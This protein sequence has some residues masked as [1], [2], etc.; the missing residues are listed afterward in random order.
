MTKDEEIQFYK[1]KL[2]TA[3]DEYKKLNS[4]LEKCNKAYKELKKKYDLHLYNVPDRKKTKS[5]EE[6]IY[7]AYPN[8]LHKQTTLIRIRRVLAEFEKAGNDWES[9]FERVKDYEKCLKRFGV[10]KNHELWRLVPTSGPWFEKGYYEKTEADWSA[11]FR[12]GRYIEEKKEP[13]EEDT[14]QPKIDELKA[15]ISEKYP[16]LEVDKWTWN[17][18]KIHEPEY[19]KYI[20]HTILNDK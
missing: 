9:L 19:A 4:R 11:P 18:I 15:I 5:I 6:K 3:R 20:K 13:E 10:D 1:D 12:N 16:A 2:Q 7:E 8:K 17:K 14:W